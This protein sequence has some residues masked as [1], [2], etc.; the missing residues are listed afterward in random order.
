MFFEQ[1]S[2]AC[3]LRDTSVTAVAAK[4]GIS[5]SNVTNWKNGTMPNSDVVVRLSELLDVSTDY[6]LLG[7][8]ET[9]ISNS[10]VGAVG[11]NS[12]GVVT[13]NESTASSQKGSTDEINSE[14]LRIL[15]ELPLRERLKLVTMIYEFEDD[16][17]KRSG[18]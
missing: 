5:K 7:K 9:A 17:K 8:E 10:N 18:K 1:L 3:E 6:L 13:I 4:L 12:N 16:Y 15:C 14:V 2:R 11:N